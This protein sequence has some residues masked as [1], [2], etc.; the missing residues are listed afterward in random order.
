MNSWNQFWFNQ[1]YRDG[2]TEKD[3]PSPIITT[4]EYKQCKNNRTRLR[5]RLSDGWRHDRNIGK[6]SNISVIFST[7]FHLIGA[8]QQIEPIAY[9]VDGNPYAR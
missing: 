2:T 9:W 8:I 5:L 7:I 1:D 4:T 6:H 3:Y